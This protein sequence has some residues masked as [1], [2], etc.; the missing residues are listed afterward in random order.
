LCTSAVMYMMSRD[1]LA[2]HI[3]AASLQLML[4]L[5]SVDV[6]QST[7]DDDLSRIR[8]RLHDI[9][10]QTGGPT[11]VRLDNMTVSQLGLC[12]F[13]LDEHVNITVM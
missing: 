1:H 13:F 9:V 11:S 10:H 7:A 4:R 5:L 2:M 12:P 8:L 6:L 3:D